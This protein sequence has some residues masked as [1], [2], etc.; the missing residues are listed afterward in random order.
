MVAVPASSGLQP[1]EPTATLGE[2]AIPLS[3]LIRDTAHA[4]VEALGL[5]PTDALVEGAADGPNA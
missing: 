2:L 4:V 5:K 3:D 1:A